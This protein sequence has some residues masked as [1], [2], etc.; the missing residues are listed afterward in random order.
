MVEVDSWHTGHVAMS[1]D[2]RL[3]F[4]TPAS[5][6]PASL[7]TG[8]FSRSTPLRVVDS[9][10]DQDWLSAFTTADVV[11]GDHG[12]MASY[13]ALINESAAASGMG[14]REV[15]NV[16]HELLVEVLAACDVTDPLEV[17]AWVRVAK[18]VRRGVQPASS[19]SSPPLRL[20]SEQ[21]STVMSVCGRRRVLL[22]VARRE[23]PTKPLRFAAI[24]P[25]EVLLRV[26]LR[27]ITLG[28]KC[29][30]SRQSKNQLS[31]RNGRSRDASTELRS[32]GDLVV[33]SGCTPRGPDLSRVTPLPVIRGEL[34]DCAA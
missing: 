10:G 20:F 1:D 30:P 7:L 3:V 2:L 26:P 14:R 34:L 27:M 24:T 21:S 16:A 8:S 32:P 18:A 4:N 11:I 9:R 5:D 28:R 23:E 25:L 13:A 22:G 15:A 19:M 17:Q 31:R 6:S 33:S 12:S 29:D